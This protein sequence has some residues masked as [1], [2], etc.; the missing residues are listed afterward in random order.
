MFLKDILL[1]LTVGHGHF[2]MLL[3]GRLASS[4]LLFAT[5]PMLKIFEPRHHVWETW[6]TTPA[7]RS[8]RW[9]PGT[10]GDKLK[11]KN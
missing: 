5:C 9:Q 3:W 11:H 6:A 2:V 7:Q 10:W 1:K 8:S 4:P